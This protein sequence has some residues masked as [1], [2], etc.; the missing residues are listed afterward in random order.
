[1]FEK[2][3]SHHNYV[4]NALFVSDEANNNKVQVMDKVHWEGSFL[5]LLPASQ[6]KS[7][8]DGIQ[9]GCGP[10]PVGYMNRGYDV[11]PYVLK[12]GAREMG[13]SIILRALTGIYWTP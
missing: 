13:K 4:V 10:N 7:I 1:M 6:L 9:I 2:F 11:E 3:K 12:Y 8:L 5:Q